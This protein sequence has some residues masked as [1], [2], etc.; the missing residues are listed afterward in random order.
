VTAVPTYV[1][2][3][4]DFDLCAGFHCETKL[5]PH[6]RMTGNVTVQYALESFRDGRGA[7]AG[8]ASV[9]LANIERNRP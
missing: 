4:S 9:A 7:G 8:V 6:D 1:A 5:P 2:V 3:S